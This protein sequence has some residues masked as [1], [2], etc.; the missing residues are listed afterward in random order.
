MNM[1]LLSCVSAVLA[2]VSAVVTV[3]ADEAIKKHA[4]KAYTDPA[5]KG[6][7]KDDAAARETVKKAHAA[8][9][10]GRASGLQKAAGTV[11]VDVVFKNGQH[12]ALGTLS[13]EGSFGWKTGEALV[14]LKLTAKK[15]E[16]KANANKQQALN[17]LKPILEQEGLEVEPYLGFAPWDSGYE[18]ARFTNDAAQDTKQDQKKNKPSG[19]AAKDGKNTKNEGVDNVKTIR[20]WTEVNK[21]WQSAMYRVSDGLISAVDTPDKSLAYE[22][23]RE[24]DATF[25]AK[26]TITIWRE[27]PYTKGREA[28]VIADSINER[29]SAST[30]TLA[31]KVTSIRNYGGEEVEMTITFSETKADKDVSAEMLAQVGIKE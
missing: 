23:V 26:H 1:R 4:N 2:I 16:K 28:V 9:T 21:A 13:Y 14:K 8:V 30:F 19:K 3:A 29:Q 6:E 22:Y 11:A 7:P 31:K 27:N 12:A 20:M 18:S 24:K 5:D 15:D 17:G 25:L 10:T